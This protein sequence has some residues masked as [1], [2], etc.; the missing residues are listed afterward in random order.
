MSNTR[1]VEVIGQIISHYKILEKL[2]EGG[3]GVVYKAHD[4]RLRRDVAMKLLPA[5]VAQDADRRDRFYI[6]ARAASALNHPNVATIY[7]IDEFEGEHFIAMEYIKGTTLRDRIASAKLMAHEALDLATQIAGGLYA[8]HQQGVVHRDIKPENILITASGLVKIMDFGLAKLASGTRLTIAG[9]TMG[10][11]AYMSP[12][13]FRGEDV[14]QRSD[15]WSFG[16]VLYEMFTQTCPFKGDSA[17]AMMFEITNKEAPRLTELRTDVPPGLEAIVAKTLAKNPA[18]RY[19]HLGELISDLELVKR[20]GVP[21]V[22][23]MRTAVKR[24][25]TRWIIA[26]AIVVL[27][28][29]GIFLFLPPPPPASA[30]TKTIAEL[31]FNNMSGNPEDEYFSDGMTED[32]LT[33]L[34]KISELKVI[35]R[36]TMMQYKG[37][38][39]SMRDIGKELNAGVVLEGSVRRAGDQVRI[40]AQLIDAG[41]DAHLWAEM[42]DKEFKQ[43]FAIQ[44]EV[45]QKIAAALE[46]KLSP[47]EKE[48]IE[49]PP[50]ASTE[51]YNYLLRAREYTRRA[52]MQDNET[53]VD[54]IKKAIDLSPEY[55]LA[56]AGLGEAYAQKY[57]RFGLANAWLDSAT[58]A[59]QRAIALDSNCAEAYHALGLTYQYRRIFE[60]S[61]DAYRKAVERNPNFAPSIMN[62]G[63]VYSSQGRFDEA[64]PWSKRGMA[65][66]PTRPLTSANIGDMYRQL[67]NFV[68]SERWLKK[69][70]DIQPDY[71][72]ANYTLASLYLVQNKDQQAN[73][74]M[75]KLVASHPNNTRV[76]DN[77]GSVADFSG[78]LLLAKQYYEESIR[79]NPSFETDPE[80]FSGIGLGR[81]LLKE[82]KRNAALTFFD[83][84]LK[85]Q[86]KQINDGNLTFFP[87][88]IL[89]SIYA[90][91]GNTKVAN[92]W[93]QK[94]V[95]AGFRDIYLNERD[96]WFEKVRSDGQY[97]QI[98][99]QLKTKLDAM[100]RKVNEM[101]AT[102]K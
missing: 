2:G 94:A 69:A 23:F 50:T 70:L 91:E 26:A 100:R 80:I 77:A 9:T 8:A 45:A 47:T 78:N 38:K 81:I 66:A 98:V 13:Q 86:Q 68:E 19:Q 43:V 58:Q 55:A 21:T 90:I 46:A 29:V 41:S 36:T 83:R 5:D 30:N 84:A 88:I 76:L 27:A 92:G 74:L 54:L 14:D 37:T 11:L 7:E 75:K 97:K 20:G 57:G 51:A 22:T 33:H 71:L 72:F 3:M 85:L 102:G 101:D 53:G 10:T 82:G 96:P 44:S 15:I 60:K 73:E 89:A 49:K 59:S 31:P 18:D 95:D 1:G 56:W 63:A 4:V 61:L 35:S 65:L 28:A 24:S 67:G 99:A 6:E 25:K 16:V 32:I 39:K 93:L 12:E 87:P 40:T 62:I 17:P 48:R 64:L 34:G 42:Y 79:T 52:K